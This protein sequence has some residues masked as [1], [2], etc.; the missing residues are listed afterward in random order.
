RG[1][2]QPIE[3]FNHMLE[4]QHAHPRA[5]Y[6]RRHERRQR[7][8][9]NIPLALLGNLGNVVV[10]YGES[11]PRDR[12]GRHSLR[13]PVYWVAERLVTG[14]RFARAIRSRTPLPDALLEHFGLTREDFSKAVSLE[15]ARTSWASFLS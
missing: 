6:G 10:A 7:T 4:R 3:A 13:W 14:E 5:G 12:T 2:E 1:L 11:T 8:F 15:E 9:G